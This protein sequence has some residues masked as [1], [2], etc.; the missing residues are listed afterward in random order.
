MNK[1]K[2]KVRHVACN[3][4]DFYADRHRFRFNY[5]GKEYVVPCYGSLTIV[6]D[7]IEKEIP[8]DILCE[9][10]A[11]IWDK[12]EREERKWRYPKEAYEIASEYCKEDFVD[13]K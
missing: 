4:E 13:E 11:I 12:I 5:N 8:E 3:M 1:T 6:F 10:Q 7:E 2:Y 9:V